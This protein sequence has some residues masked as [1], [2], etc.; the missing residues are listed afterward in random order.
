MSDRELIEAL[1]AVRARPP[2]W[3]DAAALPLLR[4]AAPADGSEEEVL[5][6]AARRGFLA[7]LKSEGPEETAALARPLA[8]RLRATDRAALARALLVQWSEAGEPSRDRRWL[9]FA[10]GLLGDDALLDALGRR[11]GEE[12]AARRH[13]VAQTCLSSLHRSGGRVARRWLGRWSRQA[14]TM[15]LRAAA[16]AGRMALTDELAGPLEVQPPDLGFDLRG[17]RAYDHA[18]RALTL[19]LGADGQIQLRD[20]ARALRSL[21]AA[22]RGTTRAPCA[23]RGSGSRRCARR[24]PRPRPTCT[25]PWRRR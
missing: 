4:L 20:G 24:S 6:E 3:V 18:G 1:E 8:P 9:L 15:R 2:R 16:W 21:P 19:Q 17:E 10:V 7:D 23:P 12:V 13:A 14:P 5:S 22:R 25:T 11:V